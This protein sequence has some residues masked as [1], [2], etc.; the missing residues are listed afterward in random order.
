MLVFGG[1]K[2]AQQIAHSVVM[3]GLRRAAIKT[4]GFVFHL[5]GEFARGVEAER[6][7]EPDRPAR[8]ETL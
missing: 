3:R 1:G 8:H 2:L 5:L 7:V 6:A 4:R